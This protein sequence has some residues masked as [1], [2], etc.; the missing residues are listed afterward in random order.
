VA[1]FFAR[2][3][4]S[5]EGQ[6]SAE[7]GDPEL[8]TLLLRYLRSEFDTQVGAWAA[9]GRDQHETLRRTCNAAE[10]LH[11]LD[12]DG[13]S[14]RMV[15]DAGN[16]LIN[17]PGLDRRANSQR[18]E[19]RMYPS[20]FKALAYIGRFFDGPEIRQ[21][22][23][24]LLSNEGHYLNISY[25]AGESPILGLCVVLDTLLHLEQS[26]RREELCSARD[27]TRHRNRMVRKLLTQIR[28]WLTAN[29]SLN[30]R[31][32]AARRS[33][34][35]NPRDLSYALG[36]LLEAGDGNLQEADATLIKGSLL[37]SIAEHDRLRATKATS[38]L[39]AALQ[40]ADHYP[41]DAK[42][43]SALEKLLSELRYA[44]GA[45]E[46]AAADRAN[47]QR[48]DLVQ[49]TLVLRLLICQYR[50]A[51]SDGMRAFTRAMVS[52][53]VRD[54]ERVHTAA[55][56]TSERELEAAV[57]NHLRVNIVGRKQLSGG[58]SED[59][60][61]LVQ[62]ASWFP[63][64]DQNG[65]LHA[66]NA[67]LIVKRSTRDAFLRAAENYRRLPQSLA[68]VFVAQPT[69]AFVHESG[70]SPT[71][72]LVMEDLTTL[73]TL[74]H[75]FNEYD[76]LIVREQHQRL[77][78]LAATE[79]CR[80]VF[81]LFRQ[82]GA[83]SAPTSQIAKLYTAPVEKKVTQTVARLP[84]LKSLLKGYPAG[85]YRF[86][87][88]D[89][90]LG[91]VGQH[92][93]ALQPRFLG[94]THNDFHARNIMLDRECAHVKLID[95]DKID[96]AGD[97][98]L[99]I[100]TVLQDL[101]VYRRV[102][103]PE[104]EFGLPF[105]QVLLGSSVPASGHD[106]ALRMPYP[107]LGRP[108]SRLL[109]EVVLRE[110]EQFAKQLGDVQWKP[111]LWLATASTLLSYLSFQ[112]QR[113]PAAVLFGEG[114]RLLD[115]LAGHLEHGRALPD[116]L[117]PEAWSERI[118]T[119]TDTIGEMPKWC[120]QSTLLREVHARMLG[121]GL[122][123]GYAVGAVRYFAA[124]ESAEPVAV[125][126]AHHGALARLKLRLMGEAVPA[127]TLAVRIVNAE[128]DSLP[129]T[130]S[131]TDDTSAEDV[132][133]LV[134]AVLG[135]LVSPTLAARRAAATRKRG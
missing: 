91:L 49:H 70:D 89:H 88:L 3:L 98:L 35:E 26:G 45:S 132:L 16:W 8:G 129:V 74:R 107:A 17:L 41:A 109:Q 93:D 20:R 110:V 29:Q 130:A 11:R 126:A 62:F 122:R 116:V 104:R 80:V 28:A 123:A 111:R 60:V 81:R 99:D 94:T 68:D 117:F 121:L 83:V 4:L 12:L 131:I 42:V 39:Y 1:D 27:Y 127:T 36:L 66:P 52:R 114:I 79:S 87:P 50:N 97:Y 23:L 43:S 55:D 10:V 40:L 46:P 18:D 61:Y 115:E 112:T 63:A 31:S 133:A 56:D 2:N 24:A 21:R 5:V 54:I 135:P 33:D 7:E 78:R 19:M 22:F 32:A 103:E 124:T 77:L 134:R 75:L 96:R 38:T 118:V 120:Q 101:C 57:R 51:G 105:D 30:G 34:I 82:P 84:W 106:E 47:I 44:Y 65:H 86:K 113:E 69:P 37:R 119:P 128:R 13:D 67:S 76:N 6:Q 9:E 15:R 59:Q 53:F 85:R 14:V 90:Y 100:A 95:L 108:A 25:Q 73:Y 64:L 48:W 72:Y 58:F 71:Y 125:L 102:T 92:A